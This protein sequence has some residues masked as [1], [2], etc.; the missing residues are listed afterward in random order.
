[1]LKSSVLDR[2]G[3][4]GSK[5]ARSAR[6]PPTER[7]LRSGLIVMMLM[8]PAKASDPYSTEPG[9][10]MTSILSMASMGK[11]SS[12]AVL[13][14]PSC[15]SRTG[16]PLINSKT[17]REVGACNASP[18]NPII[19]AIGEVPGHGG[20]TRHASQDV[21]QRR[22]AEAVQ[23]VSGQHLDDGRRVRLLLA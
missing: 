22:A 14:P 1:M 15:T 21:L 18:G 13:M 9:P 19:A 11:A 16:R 12:I 23:F 8:T 7:P 6:V 5:R 10:L 17:C 3:A 4:G 20:Q 2:R